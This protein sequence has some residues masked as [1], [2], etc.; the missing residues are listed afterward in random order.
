MPT[1]ENEENDDDKAARDDA[2]EAITAL[3]WQPADMKALLQ[4]SQ[5]T[6][7]HE[8]NSKRIRLRKKS[9]HS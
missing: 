9:N 4:Q 5:P 1:R 6:Q 7:T 3:K 2:G 8:E